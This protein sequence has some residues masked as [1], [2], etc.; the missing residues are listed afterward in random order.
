[1]ILGDS[2]SG[3]IKL[4]LLHFETLRLAQL[5]ID[6]L[7]NQTIGLEELIIPLSFGFSTVAGAIDRGRTLF[8]ALLE[9]TCE[10]KSKSFRH[11]IQEKIRKGKAFVLLDGLTEVFANSRLKLRA[12]AATF[13]AVHGPYFQD[14]YNCSRRRLSFTTN[15]EFKGD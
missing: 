8:E 15:P 3:K 2:G 4:W 1:M 14:D 5:A 9:L 12:R 7:E 6:C 10:G 13:A 11:F